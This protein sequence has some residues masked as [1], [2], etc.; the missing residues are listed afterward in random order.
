MIPW[1]SELFRAVIVAA[2]Y[3]AIF[4]IA[5]L[6]YSK[7]KTRP[8][9]TRKLVH[10][11][12]GLVALSFGYL[13]TSHWIVLFLCILFAFIIGITKKLNLLKSVHSVDRE[14]KGG[15]YYPLAIYL[16]FLFSILLDK[17]DF[18]IIAI[19]VLSIS[20]TL[21]AL[22]GHSYGIKLYHVEEAKKSFEGTVIF[23]LS[24]F[25]IVLIGILLTTDVGR[26]ESILA[27]LYIA[28]LVTSFEAISLGG[29]DN[30]FI[31]VGTIFILAKIT[32]KPPE[33]ILF[34]I[35]MIFVIYLTV[36]LI[37]S[38]Q[39]K[40]GNSGILGIALL[41]YA[42]FSLTGIDWLIPVLTGCIIVTHFDLILET[43]E[44]RDEL[45]RIRPVFYLLAV[46][47]VWILAGNAF[48]QYKYVFIIPY[49]IS[50]A[51]HFSI[52]W[53]RKYRI[54][55]TNSLNIPEILQKA[56]VLPRSIMLTLLL[57][58]P[59]FIFNSQI[60]PFISIFSCITGIIIADRL[61]WLAYSKFCPD[62]EK[63]RLWQT[64]MAIVF[65]VTLA[66]TILN[67]YLYKTFIP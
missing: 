49:V 39:K 36:Y 8:E 31:P 66:I 60:D 32:T 14:S 18:Y 27:S 26:V 59:F 67:F 3:L 28:I 54:L 24:T 16:T 10:F 46:P 13:F 20:D 11:A 9:N 48:W 23:F 53:E 6:W 19:L 34:Q 65:T 55:K 35:G 30:L 50:F 64:R 61:Y 25:I 22:I 57:L 47:L 51:A 7:G 4:A 21:A 40:L 42:A 12:G 58:G 44:K 62:I 63:L 15:I 56:P 45:Y 2:A 17:P 52:M 37:A 33:E 29:A 1:H 5:E 38:S 41:A 43:P